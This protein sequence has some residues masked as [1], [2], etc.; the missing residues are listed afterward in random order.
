[1]PYENSLLFFA[2][3]HR[4]LTKLVSFVK[5][6]KEWIKNRSMDSKISMCVRVKCVEK[7]KKFSL[8]C[9]LQCWIS[10]KSCI[11]AKM[12][13]VTC[14]AIHERRKKQKKGW[15]VNPGSECICD[16]HSLIFLRWW[17]SGQETYVEIR[18][19]SIV[20]LLL[21]IQC[22][23]IYRIRLQRKRYFNEI[24]HCACETIHSVHS[25]ILQKYLP[26][27]FVKMQKTVRYLKMM[28]V[29]SAWFD[30]FQFVHHL[31]TGRAWYR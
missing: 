23:W 11:V 21:L 10:T 4:T 20:F 17:I 12:K 15:S 18:F 2:S 24:F 7:Y 5:S 31:H 13:S 9:A 1:M 3:A 6:P 22:R 27:Y 19:R 26:I 16:R 8:R 28:S 29:A 14:S 30:Q 25:A